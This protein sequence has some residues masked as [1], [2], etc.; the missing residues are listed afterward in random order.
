MAYCG[1]PRTQG[2]AGGESLAAQ[3]IPAAEF[4]IWE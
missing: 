3:E 2:L 4:L 1:S